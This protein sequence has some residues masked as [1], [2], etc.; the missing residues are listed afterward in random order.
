MGS[1]DF[2]RAVTMTCA[3]WR[4]IEHKR[5][6]CVGPVRMTRSGGLELMGDM[7]NMPDRRRC[8]LVVE[9]EALISELV[10]E[11]LTESGFTVHAVDAGEDA[12]RYLEAGGEADVL[13]TDINL[14]GPMDGAALAQAV[15]ARRPEMP[16]VYCSGR[17]SPSALAPPVTRSVFVKKPY[18]PNDVC[19]LL[20]RLTAASHH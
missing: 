3:N 2:N 15:R 7:A 1:G 12:L 17:Y 13:F 14:V 20:E 18:S 8:V 5:P 11:V 16:I 19:R 9:D 4:K 6:M 10:S